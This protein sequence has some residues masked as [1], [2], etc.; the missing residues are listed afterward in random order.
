MAKNIVFSFDDGRLD[1]Y[2]NAVPIMDQ[3]GI[4]ATINITADFI[5]HAENY[6]CFKSANN[7]AMSIEQVLE[8]YN[9]GFE[10]ATHGNRHTND[11][12]DVRTSIK[13]LKEWGIDKI[14]GFASPESEINPDNISTF[15]ELMD[16]GTISYIRSGFQVRKR[17]LLYS[18]LYVIQNVTK[19]KNL[20]YRL[21]KKSVFGNDEKQTLLYGISVT[22]DTTVDQ[23]LYFIDKMPENSTAILIFHSVLESDDL[24]L[25]KDKWYWNVERFKEL[26][27]ELSNKK[28]GVIKNSD[29][30]KTVAL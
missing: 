17:G 1:T 7:K 26:C 22:K 12:D 19:S 28:C 5:L 4:K 24:G 2:E 8:L 21:N 18:A 27:K 29:F 10:I 13:I 14:Y 30:Y 23:I 16:D 11:P 25:G 9:K 3:Y 6:N 15:K 20:F